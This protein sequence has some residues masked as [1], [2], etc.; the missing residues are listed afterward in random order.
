MFADDEVRDT[1]HLP[2]EDAHETI[3]GTFEQCSRSNFDRA[4]LLVIDQP[5]PLGVLAAK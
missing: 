5:L 3:I 1:A 4:E 2:H